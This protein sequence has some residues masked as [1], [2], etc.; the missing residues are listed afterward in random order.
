MAKA[1]KPK[2]YRDLKQSLLDDLESRGLVQD[3]YTDMVD[4]YM[5][6]W[7]RRQELKKDI[8]ENGVSLMD[9]KRGMRVE[10]RS[11][12]LESQVVT[13]MLRL[14][15]ALGFQDMAAAAKPGGVDD[16]L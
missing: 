2:A 3:V 4:Q 10:N 16:E 6:L 5:D 14:F 13:Q 8:A 9:P 11:V 1:K 7:E 15:K 12:M